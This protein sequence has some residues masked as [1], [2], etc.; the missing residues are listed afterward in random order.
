MGKTRHDGR[1]KAGGY[2]WG[3]PH[4]VSSSRGNRIFAL[5]KRVDRCCCAS[6]DNNNWIG[7]IISDFGTSHA[8]SH[9][10][11]ITYTPTGLTSS[12]QN[13]LHSPNG[14]IIKP[15]RS[16]SSNAGI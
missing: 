8:S 7:G 10:I 11:L 14:A 5:R 16:C 6:R 1:R 9:C 13:V 4:R 3:T 12:I 15:V 2:A